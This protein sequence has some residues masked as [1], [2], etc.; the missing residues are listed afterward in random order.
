MT[1]KMI[2]LNSLEQTE[3]TIE[4]ADLTNWQLKLKKEKKQAQEILDV[5]KIVP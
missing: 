2:L 4:N 1:D 5:M 3:P